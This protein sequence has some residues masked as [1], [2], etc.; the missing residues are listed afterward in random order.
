[1]R[2]ATS[3][4]FLPLAASGQGEL[5]AR[6][7]AFESLRWLPGAPGQAHLQLRPRGAGGHPGAHVLPLLI[8]SGHGWFVG[9]APGCDSLG[10]LCIPSMGKAVK[11]QVALH[12]AVQKGSWDEDG[13]DED[14]PMAAAFGCSSWLP[15]LLLLYRDHMSP[16][17]CLPFLCILTQGKDIV[18]SS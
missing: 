5:K 16:G 6:R 7:L 8:S 10:P 17:I 9:A 18:R 15:V 12:R 4:R 3:V 11:L 1:M 14:G 2:N 13:E